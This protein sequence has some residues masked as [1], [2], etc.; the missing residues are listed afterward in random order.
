MIKGEW[1]SNTVIKC[2][3]PKYTKP[4]VL[5]VEITLNG[6]D[7]THDGK[8]YG[9][10]DPYVLDA[11]PRLINVDGSTKVQIKGFGFVDSGTTQAKFDSEKEHLVTSGKQNA[12]TD[13]KF[14]D[15]NTLLTN[16]LPQ[17]ALSYEK[18]GENVW[19][20]AM[21]IEASVYEGDFTENGIELFYIQDPVYG[22][23]NIDES[24]ANIENQ[25]FIPTDFKNTNPKL[26]EKYGNLTC[27]FTAEDGTVLFT[28]AK[29]VTYPLTTSKDGTKPNTIQCHTPKW[30]LK[31][32]TSEKTTL[33]LSLNG[34]NFKGGF[35]F[36]FIQQLL[37]YRTVPMAGPV[38]G[39]TKTRVIGSGFKPTK[40]NADLK[41]GVLETEVM[42]KEQ[43]TEYIYYKAQFENM[44]EGSE[45]IKSYVYE[46]AYFSRVDLEMFEE[47][48]YH[49]TYLKTPRLSWWTKT[50]GG[51]YYVEVG[52]DIKIEVSSA[53][54][55]VNLSGSAGSETRTIISANEV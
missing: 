40:S 16:T 51:P 46:A 45:E 50:H 23:P 54:K 37:I 44:I 11:V 18:S 15:K 7:F 24:P 35:E 22:V 29:M 43:V 38:Q 2:K 53:M 52:T 25:L 10:F 13:A 6:E 5:R 3:I 30:N 12:V 31:G 17:T 21:T 47:S 36:T 20:D 48:S 8:T 4:D 49:S 55:G 28:K 39:N 1:I 41:W 27:R 34:Q 32:K 42:Y 9:Y 19:W 33:D 26:L 14:I